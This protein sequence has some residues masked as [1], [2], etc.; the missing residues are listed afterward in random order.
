MNTETQMKTAAQLVAA[1]KENVTTCTPLEASQRLSADASAIILDIREASEREQ[2]H[3]E[4]STHIPRG[5]LEWKIA[6]AC[7]DPDQAILIHCASGGRAALAVQS[8][9]AMGYQDVTA[10]EGSCADI[11]ACMAGA[12]NGAPA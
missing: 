12:D 1:A 3:V 6:E 5:L 4:G 11:S 8:L 9:V 2:G 7:P 10:V